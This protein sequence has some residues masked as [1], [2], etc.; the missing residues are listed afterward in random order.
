VIKFYTGI[1]FLDIIMYAKFGED[2]L[3]SWA[4]QGFKFQASSSTRVVDLYNTPALPCE[5]NY[6][7]VSTLCPGKKVT[8]RQCAIE[9]PN[10]NVSW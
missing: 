10:L 5:C 8:P 9:M 4:L 6:Y 3:R 1:D 7:V 2:Q